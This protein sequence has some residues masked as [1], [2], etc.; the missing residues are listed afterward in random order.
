[1]NVAV[2]PVPALGGTELAAAL[3]TGIHRLISR[4]EVINKIN[5][6]PVPDG[7]TGTNLALTLQAVGRLTSALLTQNRSDLATADRMGI[8]PRGRRR[9]VGNGI[10]LT[11]FR[12]RAV[13]REG[14]GPVV[15]TCVAR[16]E[17]V[18][19]HSMLFEAIRILRGRGVAIRLRLLG[20]GPLRSASRERCRERHGIPVL[21][22]LWRDLLFGAAQVVQQLGPEVH[23]RQELVA[24][25]REHAAALVR[26]QEVVDR[27]VRLVDHLRRADPGQLHESAPGQGRRH[28]VRSGWRLSLRRVVLRD[29]PRHTSS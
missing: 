25:L 11:R 20:E 21:S 28:R 5:V 22:N 24:D 14:A 4:E 13:P 16:F 26:G 18:K 27:R 7:D 23:R 8:G 1:M 17:P 3:R 9:C 6:F 19:N 2:Q 15:V 12:P 10:D 29:G